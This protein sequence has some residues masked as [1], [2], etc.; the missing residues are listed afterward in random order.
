MPPPSPVTA[1]LPWRLEEMDFSKLQPEKVR[2]DETLFFLLVTSS[3]V[4]AA[5]NLYTQN[6]IEYYAG[7]HEVADWL[8]GHW[9]QEELQHGRALR[10][11]IGA[12]WPQFDWDR[13]SAAFF[14]E[15]SLMCTLDE[16]EPTRGLEM[17]ARCV[18]ETGT[19]SLYRAVHDYTSEPLLKDLM[20]RIKSDEIRHF[21]HFYQYFRKYSA[22]EVVGRLNVIRAIVKRIAEAKKEDSLV[23]YKHAFGAR[24]PEV[25]FDAGHYRDYSR[26]LE[27]IMKQHFPFEMSIK[28]LLRPVDLPP[29][30]RGPLSRVLVHGART[31]IF[32]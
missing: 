23:A 18:V 5:S 6:L 10:A 30:I 17:A 32:G 19:S 29:R 26:K 12:V 20:S 15:Y 25:P 4:E 1:A 27:A 7:D 21:S 11:Y 3:F 28:M 31:F 9:E 14:E 16:F 24:F 13:G 8:A 22:A 2:D